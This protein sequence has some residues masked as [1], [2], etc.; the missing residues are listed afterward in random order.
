MLRRILH[1]ACVREIANAEEALRM[2]ARSPHRQIHRARKALRR[3]RAL[4]ALNHHCD[5]VV[6]KIDSDLKR[7]VRA[8]SPLRDSAVAVATLDQ[9]VKRK[10]LEID[11]RDVK[12]L[13]QQL[14]SRRDSALAKAQK[15]DPE[16]WKLRARLRV[17]QEYARS[18]TWSEVTSVSIERALDRA[19]RRVVKVENVARHSHAE[20]IRHRWRRRLRRCNDQRALIADLLT[21]PTLSNDIDAVELIEHLR[22]G[23]VEGTYTAER[24][25]GITHAL[26][27]EHDMRLLRRLVR[28][29]EALGGESRDRLLE[30]IEHR[31]RRL[32]KRCEK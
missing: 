3:T 2:S 25:A 31:L 9:V 26:G 10:T 7:V 21:A 27:V 1:D 28:K 29:T 18:F 5:D 11:S 16:F 6:A 8:L 12:A 30:T 15:R 32:H 13:R 14:V 17:V 20:H 24:V 4:L 22:S 19:M 23:Y